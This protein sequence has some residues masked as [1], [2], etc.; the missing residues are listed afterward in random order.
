MITK[1]D[2]QDAYIQYGLE[3]I[4]DLIEKNDFK[5]QIWAIELFNEPEWITIPNTQGVKNDASEQ[6]VV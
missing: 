6:K 4:L 3:P 5:D 2:N 1:E